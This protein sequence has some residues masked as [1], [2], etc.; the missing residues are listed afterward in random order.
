MP[1]VSLQIPHRGLLRECTVY[2]PPSYTGKTA[3]PL[4]LAFHGG[5]A[6]GALFERQTQLSR[7]A[8]RQGFIV[9]YPE[10]TGVWQTWN[11]GHC[12][13]YAQ[14][15]DIDDVGFTDKLIDELSARFKVTKFFATG[16]SNGGC[17]CYRLA[18]EIPDRIAAIAVVSGSM[19]SRLTP[20]ANMPVLIV[21]GLE[22]RNGPWAGGYG[23]DA[24]QKINHQAGDVTVAKWKAVSS[25]VEV[26]LLP[27][28]GHTWLLPSTTL[29]VWEF[30][31]ELSP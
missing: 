10:G 29:K 26:Q 17:F 8:D 31:K 2:V 3:V 30:F 18:C 15:L 23:P 24:V 27:S 16:F 14:V 6:D 4:V 12:C 13:G 22:D 28:V 5:L 1:K 21:H 20:E 19:W 7:L 11:A 9:A 25:K